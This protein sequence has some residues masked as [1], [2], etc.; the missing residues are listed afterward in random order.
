MTVMNNY[1]RD[2]L[3]WQYKFASHTSE[4]YDHVIQLQNFIVKYSE[5]HL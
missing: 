4:I 1:L 3:S 2:I 5:T